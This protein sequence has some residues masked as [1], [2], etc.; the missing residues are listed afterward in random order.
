MIIPSGKKGI[1][2]EMTFFSDLTPHHNTITEFTRQLMVILRSRD[3]N[4]FCFVR[5]QKNN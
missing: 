4:K 2:S 5:D 1:L 3:V